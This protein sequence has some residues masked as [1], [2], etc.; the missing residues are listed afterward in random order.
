M[1]LIRH[2]CFLLNSFLLIIPSVHRLSYFTT[3]LNRQEIN[4]DFPLW[5]RHCV[6][7]R[8]WRLLTISYVVRTQKANNINFTTA[9]T[10]IFIRHLWAFVSKVAALK[11][12]SPPKLSMH[13]LSPTQS[14]VTLLQS[15]QWSVRLRQFR[16]NCATYGTYVRGFRYHPTNECQPSV[17]NSN[18]LHVLTALPPG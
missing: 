17:E 13:S 15:T 12:I 3:P 8:R 2:D 6:P 18:Y 5:W 9:E 11:D 7:L 4:I 10:S 14:E 1:S 16:Q